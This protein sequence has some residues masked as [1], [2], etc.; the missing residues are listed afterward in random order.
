MP[1]TPAKNPRKSE[2]EVEMDLDVSGQEEF[3][4]LWL[5]EALRLVRGERRRQY[6]HVFHNWK[7]LRHMWSLILGVKVSYT[8]LA[9]C[10]MAMKMCRELT[11]PHPKG[12][13]NRDI[14]GYIQCLQDVEMMA[15]EVDNDGP[16]PTPDGS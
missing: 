2:G 9:Y 8:Q 16:V 15:K 4:Q 11:N 6:G 7:R 14:A 1:K 12:D 5:V 13:N 10:I 3:D